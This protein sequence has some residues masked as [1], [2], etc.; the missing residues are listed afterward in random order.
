VNGRHRRCVSPCVGREVETL[1]GRPRW[2]H[3][4]RRRPTAFVAVAAVLALL[5]VAGCG[6]TPPV[7]VLR[8]GEGAI[9]SPAFAVEKGWYH[10]EWVAWDPRTTTHGCLFGLSIEVVRASVADTRE[11]PEWGS[12]KLMYQTLGVAGQINGQRDA[13]FL[14]TASYILRSDGGCAWH[15]EVIPADAPPSGSPEPVDGGGGAGGGPADAVR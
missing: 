6:L 11:L 3:R 1:D 7:R 2:A 5:A 9:A 10:I 15:A 14:P 13:V 8:G 4:R 12:Q